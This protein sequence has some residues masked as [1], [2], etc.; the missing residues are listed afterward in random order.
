MTLARRDRIFGNAA[1]AALALAL[2]TIA[3]V[4][5]A[6]APL[7][8][9]PFAGEAPGTDGAAF[10][11]AVAGAMRAALA[12]GGSHAA[13]DLTIIDE[14]TPEALVLEGTLAAAAAG[15]T[16]A[17][18]VRDPAGALR[19]SADREAA[20]TTPGGAAAALAKS[21]LDQLCRAAAEA[22]GP[23]WW[24]ASVAVDMPDFEREFWMV[25]CGESQFGLWT[26][27]PTDP[28]F[29]TIVHRGELVLVEATG[30]GDY[31]LEATESGDRGFYRETGWAELTEFDAGGGAVQIIVLH[32]TWSSRTADGKG[33]YVAMD[34]PFGD[35]T[36]G[37]RRNDGSCPAPPAAN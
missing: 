17:A 34:F 8:V 7:A 29:P 19:A 23:T 3:A 31:W 22:P 15:I 16:A 12:P 4:P 2:L 6:A 28:G 1:G 32:G 9:R 10:A 21:I 30:R 18:E 5:A 14:P 33:G 35:M 13:C 36:F 27:M 11:D 24:I 37:L 26:I 20:N 25:R